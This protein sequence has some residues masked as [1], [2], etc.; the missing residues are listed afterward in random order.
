MFFTD[1][2][3]DDFLVSPNTRV[4]LCDPDDPVANLSNNA[5]E[6]ARHVMSLLKTYVFKFKSFSFLSHSFFLE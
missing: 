4:M 2:N 5:K 1:N 3:E 6:W